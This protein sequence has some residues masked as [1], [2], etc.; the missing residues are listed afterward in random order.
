[1]GPPTVTAEVVVTDGHATGRLHRTS[2]RLSWYAGDSL[3]VHLLLLA[4]PDHPALP[5]G[6]WT[7]LRDFLRYS[8]SHPTGDGDVRARPDADGCGVVLDLLRDGRTTTVR[9]P[10]AVVER[11]LDATEEHV[12]AGEE[13]S[14]EALDELLARLATA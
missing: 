9:V 5:R 4:Q 14:G 11:F 8:L 12:A 10:A 1:M 3:A 13:R 6:R 2:L 7:L